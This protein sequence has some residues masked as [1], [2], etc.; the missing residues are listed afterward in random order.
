MTREIKNYNGMI[1]GQNFF[2]QPVR[3][4]LTTYDNIWKIATGQGDDHTTGSLLDYN[5]FKRY[6]KMMAMDLSKQKALDADPKA[7]K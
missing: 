6:Y 7:I 3:N 1:N 4:D 2:N 5:Y